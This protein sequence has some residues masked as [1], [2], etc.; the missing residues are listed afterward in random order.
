[1]GKVAPLYDPTSESHLL[2]RKLNWMREHRRL[3]IEKQI[4]FSTL[5]SIQQ[6][7]TCRHYRNICFDFQCTCILIPD[8]LIQTVEFYPSGYY[9]HCTSLRTEISKIDLLIR[10]D[11]RANERNSQDQTSFQAQ[12]TYISRKT[13]SPLLWVK[14]ISGSS[15]VDLL[16]RY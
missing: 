6:L 3:G 12:F 9:G 5:P 10:V 2:Y 7:P 4:C 11:M 1:M 14:V 13:P 16:Q 8:W 15:R